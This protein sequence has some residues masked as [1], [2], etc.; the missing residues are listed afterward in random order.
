[1]RAVARREFFAGTLRLAGLVA[2]LATAGCTLLGGGGGSGSLSSGASTAAAAFGSAS[3]GGSAGGS[4]SAGAGGTGT[5]STSS[6]EG[7]AETMSDVTTVHKPE[8]LS[9]A[10]FGSGLLGLAAWRRRR[11]R[12]TG[13]R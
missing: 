13:S 12:R 10:L 6:G 7:S 5:S 9:S 3:S 1:M 2:L 4:S 8:P 11:A